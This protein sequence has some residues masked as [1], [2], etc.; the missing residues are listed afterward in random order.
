[1]AEDQPSRR[2]QASW[3]AHGNISMLNDTPP[4]AMTGITRPQKEEKEETPQLQ[5]EIHL[6]LKNQ[7][8]CSLYR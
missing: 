6:F 3:Y 2:P 1:M 4:S 7:C 8:I 5:E